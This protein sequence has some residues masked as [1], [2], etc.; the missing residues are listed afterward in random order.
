M[1]NLN[2]LR[3]LWMLPLF[4][5]ALNLHAQ[6]VAKTKPSTSTQH[7]T[8]IP[9]RSNVAN[10]LKANEYIK[11]GM[12]YYRA[13]NYT[14]AA[15]YLEKAANLGEF[16]SQSVLGSMYMKGEG[17]PQDYQ[18]AKYWL[19]KSANQQFAPA[20]FG[21]GLMYY[22]G[23][24]MAKDDKK[25]FFWVEKAATQGNGYEQ[26]RLKLGEMYLRGEGVSQDY[27]K[28]SSLLEKIATDKNSLPDNAIQAML[29]LSVMYMKGEGVQDHQKA[30]L[31]AEKAADMGSPVA[32]EVLGH[33]QAE[34]VTDYLK[35][36]NT[37]Q[38]N[39]ETYYLGWSSH[40][41][42]IYYIQEYFPKDE[43]A[44][45]YH[46]MFSVSILYGEALTPKVGADTK[47]AELEL[48][49]STDACCNYKVL[50][51]GDSY[52]VDF[53]VSQ[54]DEK[55]PELLSV[56]EFNLYLYRQVTINGKKALE[57]D[58]YSRRAYGEE[59]IPFLQTLTE[60]RKEAFA[61]M[62]KTDIQCH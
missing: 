27:Q 9:S 55:N 16:T 2:L 31:W 53:L 28:A 11:K 50:N 14:Q 29:D 44:E 12:E 35:V 13:K 3:T 8:T 56:V 36:G 57:L 24:G 22:Q 19:E 58:F 61:E 62:T 7:L 5:L 10:R 47:V 21:L 48:R 15:S 38:F 32:K 49:K 18:K 41:T 4:C 42:D 33:L 43:K 25:A 37:L 54:K 6:G 59:I 1:K 17:V 26:A 60:T 45:S 52:M 46:Q 34:S 23:L 30:L 20:Q 51:N 40:P 39:K